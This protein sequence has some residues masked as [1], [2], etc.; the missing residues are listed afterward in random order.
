LALRAGRKYLHFDEEAAKI[1][2]DADAS[3]AAWLD[4]RSFRLLGD[5]IAL[6]VTDANRAW[7][8]PGLA[9]AEPYRSI[10]ATDLSSINDRSN[11][12]RCL[13]Q[14]SNPPVTSRGEISGGTLAH[15]LGW[16]VHGNSVFPST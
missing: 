14:F 3:A 15:Q 13:N 6:A 2:G 11:Q 16:T 7:A 9:Q 5:L 10:S 12:S 8:A 4:G 1:R